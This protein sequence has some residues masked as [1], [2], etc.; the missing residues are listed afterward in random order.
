LIKDHL[1]KEYFITI[2]IVFLL[3]QS[4]HS[5]NFINSI[6]NTD[7]QEFLNS[8]DF[9]PSDAKVLGNLNLEY[10]FQDQLLDYRNL[11]YLKEN[12]LSVKDYIEKNHIEYIILYEEM[13]YIHRNSPTW[14]ILYGELYYYED[15]KDYIDRK[16]Q[17][18]KK[19]EDQTYGIRIARYVNTYPWTIKVYKIK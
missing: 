19:F 4:Y 17:L 13:D 5:Y 14:D 15:L 8:F 10:K 3:L 6:D 9:I 16:M 2:L 7:Y 11:Y 12:N 1:Q 18:V